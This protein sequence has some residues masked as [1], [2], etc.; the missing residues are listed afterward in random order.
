MHVF[1]DL[2]GVLL[3]SDR[4]QREYGPELARQMSA[5]FGGDADPWVRAHTAAWTEYVRAVERVDWGRAAWS[6]TVGTLDG[7]LAVRILELADVA[8]R[9][10][11][12]VAFSKELDAS[13]MSRI[14][15]RFPDARTAVERLR[16]EDHRVYVATQASEANALGA[17]RGAGLHE[18]FDGVFTGSG[19][20]ALKSS[21]AYWDGIRLRLG[22]RD[23]EGVAVDDRPDYLE[24]ATSAGFVGLLLDRDGVFAAEH[25]PRYVEAILRNLA[26]LPHYVGLLAS[27]RP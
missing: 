10:P 3:D 26:G 22:L 19:L 17:L 11:D 1:L 9:P 20:D 24:A 21:R 15:A 25:A 18:A 27:R 6:D 8:W 7:Q 16:A 23:R 5:R 12:P 14:N 2:W 13:V 4:M